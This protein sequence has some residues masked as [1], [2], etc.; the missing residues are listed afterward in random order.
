MHG[1]DLATFTKKEKEKKKGSLAAAG[2]K[3]GVGGGGGGGGVLLNFR[4]LCTPLRLI[5]VNECRN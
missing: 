1:Y 2:C 4:V 5:L 3:R